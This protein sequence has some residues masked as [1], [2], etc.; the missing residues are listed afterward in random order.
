MSSSKAFRK[1]E[2][3]NKTVIDSSGKVAGKVKDLVFTLD[4][5]IT[6]IVERTDGSEVQIPLNKVM[7]VSDHVIVKEEAF[8]A[9]P[10]VM[11]AAA[12]PGNAAPSVG[13]TVTCKTCGSQA[14]AGTTWCP[15]CGRALG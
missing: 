8:M 4:G 6:L 3:A 11:A 15:G 14:P 5:A 13:A 12:G 1:E 7:G 10:M 9:R 2:I